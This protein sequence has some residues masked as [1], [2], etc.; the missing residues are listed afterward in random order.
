[1]LFNSMYAKRPKIAQT[2]ALR[3]SWY[4]PF[5]AKVLDNRG[6]VMLV[7]PAIL[8]ATAFILPRG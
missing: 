5:L 6:K 2:D 4:T 7:A 3:F 8:V 1:M